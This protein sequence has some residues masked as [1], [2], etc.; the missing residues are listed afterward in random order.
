MNILKK[1]K[2]LNN[3]KNKEI[4]KMISPQKKYRINFLKNTDKMGLFEEDKLLLVGD[5]N[6][7]GIYQPSNKIWVWASSIPGVNKKQIKNIRKIKEM[8]HLFEEDDEQVMNFYYQLLTQDMLLITDLK[9]LDYINMLILYLSD[10]VY[11]FNPQNS[12]GNIQFLT[13]KKITEKYI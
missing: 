13:F 9:M 7:Y 2:E 1:I 10:D 8:S 4:D 11:Y 12:D 5:Y 6:F 3:K